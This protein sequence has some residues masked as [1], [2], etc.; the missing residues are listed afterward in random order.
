M[1]LL[2][3]STV[4]SFSLRFLSSGALRIGTRAGHVRARPGV[5]RLTGSPQTLTCSASSSHGP[6]DVIVVGGGHAGCEAAAAAARTGAKTLL[7]TQRAETIGEM[8][9]NPSIGGIGKGHLVREVDA[10]DGLMG[11]VIDKAGIHF[12]MLNRRKGAAVRGPRAQADRDIYRAT[13]QELLGEMK[14]LEIVEGSAEDLLLEGDQ[15]AG[16]VLADGRELQSKTV[17]ITTGTFLRGK[18][19]IG[20]EWYWA[21]RHMRD[22]DEVEPPSV[23]LAETLE[24][25]K[26]PLARLKTG[27]PAR[28]DGN[29][30]NWGALEAQPSEIPP[31][32]FSYMNAG[33]PIPANN[34][35]ISCARVFTNEATH[36]IVREKAH[37]LPEEARDGIG[38]RYCP[39]I[40]KKCERFPDRT[41]HL[42]WLEPEGLNTNVVYPNGMSGPYP[43]EVQLEILRTMLG[44][45]EVEIIRPG[46]DVEYDYVQPTSLHHTLQTRMVKGLFLAGQICGTTGYEEAAAQGIVAG[47]NAGFQ[48]LGRPEFTIGRDEGYIG[49]LI[50]DLVT[51]GTLEPYRMFT[52]RAEYRLYLRADNA[53]LRLTQK[54]Y[55]AGL[56]GEERMLYLRERLGAIGNSLEQ[57][58]STSLETSDWVSLRVP[59]VFSKGQSNGKKKNGA[60]VLAMPDV[61]LKQVGLLEQHGIL[62]ET[63]TIPYRCHKVEDALTLYLGAESLDMVSSARERL[64]RKQVSKIKSAPT[65]TPEWAVDSVEAA[66]KYANYMDR[67]VKEMEAWRRNQDMKIPPDL[68][69]SADALPPLSAEELEKLNAVRPQTF[70]A[71]SQISGITPN[72]MVYLYHYVRKQY[73]D[74][75][76]ERSKD[77]GRHHFMEED[78]VM[79]ATGS[80]PSADTERL[81]SAAAAAAA[82]SS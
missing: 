8:S 46:Y 37:L 71:A 50:D 19:Y 60:E 24:R 6:A 68:K 30:I 38:P 2:A 4:P 32:P 43:E 53:D 25:F 31:Q 74:R 36:K 27:T 57:L 17:V 1:S 65:P 77:V 49:V 75:D 11:R 15:I 35:L 47:A 22:S 39:S 58:K 70:A 3:A 52:S 7:V 40:Y 59:L 16:L 63:L 45:E 72:S 42:S 73:L 76:Q 20:K 81:A 55:D 67:Q 33:G 10:L 9:C 80:A 28:I 18:C 78:E 41:Q 61:T 12:R 62:R 51:K 56:V 66:C 48:A 14:M 64:M 13:M 82:A 29:T 23:G 21:G 5:R 54:G 69:Y 44:L 26:F 34:K 79:E